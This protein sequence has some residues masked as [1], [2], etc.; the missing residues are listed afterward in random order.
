[1]S[2]LRVSLVSVCVLMQLQ[3]F[4]ACS[5][6]SL[7]QERVRSAGQSSAEAPPSGATLERPQRLHA[8]SSPGEEE[9]PSQ[10]GLTL[11]T[12]RNLCSLSLT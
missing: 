1:M 5:V 12:G 9:P 2:L 4:H 10:G 8:R 6:F 7:D 11:Q 3:L